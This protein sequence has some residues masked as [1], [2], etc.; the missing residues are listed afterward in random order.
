[1]DQCEKYP[2]HLQY[3]CFFVIKQGTIFYVIFYKTLVLTKALSPFGLIT[4]S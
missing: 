1:M 2:T 3:G 4:S